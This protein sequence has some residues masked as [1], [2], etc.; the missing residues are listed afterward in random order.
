MTQPGRAP[1]VHPHRIGETGGVSDLYR[2][3]GGMDTC[4]RLSV[5]LYGHVERDP[6]LRP[7][8]PTT[9]RCAIESFTAFLAQFLGGPAEYTPRR[10]SLSLRDAHLRFPIGQAE[11]DAW[12]RCMS[13]ALDDAHVEEPALGALRAF[14]ARSS[15]HIVNRGQ[16]PGAGRPRPEPPPGHVHADVAARWEAYRATEDAVAAV[17]SGDAGRALALVQGPTLRQ[18]FD[19]DRAALVSLL[20]LMSGDGH[21]ALVAHVR[22]ELLRHPALVRERYVYGRTLLHGASAEGGV[23]TVELLLELGA[24]PDAADDRGRTPLHCAGNECGRPEGANVVR[25]LARAGAHVDAVDT[26]RRCAPLHMAARRGTVA[27]AE[28]LLDCGADIEAR[29]R[30]GDTPLRRAVNCGKVE[31]AAFLASRGAD[32]HSRGGRGLTPA[33]AARTRA[34]EEALR[35]STPAQ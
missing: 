19:H 1:A 31:M 25:A 16:G 33:L 26:G 34:M 32:V 28:A 27:I 8:F 6:L 23:A 12:L 15:S 30:L 5:A 21:P 10:W 7:L 14:F 11:R 35:L 3:I 29:D 9:F 24:D 18:A 2:A 22:Q 13:M 17:R 20:V 4:Q